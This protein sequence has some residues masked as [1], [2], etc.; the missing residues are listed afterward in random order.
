MR[1]VIFFTNFPRLYLSKNSNFKKYL[2]S[3]GIKFSK[4]DNNIKLDG[5]TSSEVYSGLF[6]GKNCHQEIKKPT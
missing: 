3:S 1:V 5:E 4:S 6:L 2:F